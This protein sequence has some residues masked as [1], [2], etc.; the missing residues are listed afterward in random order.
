MNNRVAFIDFVQGLLHLDP[1]QRWS[2][3]QARL[4]PFV[5][6]EPL[7]QPF[8]PPQ[9]LKNGSSKSVPA[10]PL[11]DQGRTYGSAPQRLATRTYENV[12]Y[13][14]HIFPLM[15]AD[16]LF[17]QCLQSTK[18]YTTNV[19]CSSSIGST[20]WSNAFEFLY[21]TRSWILQFE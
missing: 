2:P 13:V 6:G 1:A 4:H 12:P 7:L 21:F 17:R 5:L 16:H 20:T 3:Q 14:D 9:M 10:S 18:Q 11:P 15:L 19:Q 8:V